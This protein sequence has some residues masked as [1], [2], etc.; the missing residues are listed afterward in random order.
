YSSLSYLRQFAIDRLKIDQSFV[1]DLPEDTDAQ[2]IICAIVAM[3]RS[4]GLR[5]IV[6]GVETEGQAE[7]L[8]SVQCDESQGYLYA[9]P[10]MPN[11]FEAWVKTRNPV[12]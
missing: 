1:R 10:M 4:L 2:A 12:V 7:Y 11:D 5:V 3:G 6:E 9:R 8:R